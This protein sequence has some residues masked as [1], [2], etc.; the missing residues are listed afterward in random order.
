MSP[1]N[2]KVLRDWFEQHKDKPYPV[3]KD[4][5]D[6]VRQTGLLEYQIKGFLN[7]LRRQQRKVSAINVH[8]LSRV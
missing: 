2:Q 3:K 6:L 4:L 7:N 8:C 1:A 5:D